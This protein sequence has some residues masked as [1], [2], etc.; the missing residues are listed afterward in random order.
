M[1]HITRRHFIK[2]AGVV[3]AATW[4]PNLRG[5]QSQLQSRPNII[6][7]M[8]DD[9]GYECLG[10]NGSLAYRTP[11]IDE[12]AETGVRFEQAHATPLCTPSRVQLMTG[13]YNFRNYTEFG[14]LPPGQFTLI[15]HDLLNPGSLNDYI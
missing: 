4:L 2:T 11:Q 14:S 8:A 1:N 13:K 12:L 9:F 3:S 5:A 6:L 15:K 10:C 7:I